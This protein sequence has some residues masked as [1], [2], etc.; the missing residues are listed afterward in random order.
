VILTGTNIGDYGIDRGGKLQIDDLIE[1]LLS[2]TGIERLRVS[3]LDPTEISDR[4]LSFFDRYPNF[5]PHFHVSLQHVSSKILK[6]MKRKYQAEDVE[7]TLVKLSKLPRKPFVGMD[8][9]T[10]FPGETEA[11][12]LESIDTLKRL[13][14]SRLHVFPYSEREGTPATRLPNAVAPSVRKER[15]RILQ[16]LSL[17]R[18][19]QHFAEERQKFEDQQTGILEGVLL[20]G[21]VKGPNGS[22]LWISGYSPHYQRV[23]L[24]IQ[25]DQSESLRNEM[26]DV[27]ISHWIL[28]RAT[29]EISWIGEWPSQGDVNK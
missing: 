14:W 2:Q 16:Q 17:E 8:Y 3:S 24:P 22:K 6:L 19:T 13:P 4:M 26:T 9:I 18:L 15:A 29:G 25:E 23:L 12:F 7:K 5:C 1:A 10:G 20:E 11:D 21:R 28:D 27:K